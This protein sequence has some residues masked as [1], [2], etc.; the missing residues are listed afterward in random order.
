MYSLLEILLLV[1]LPNVLCIIDQEGPQQLC[2]G[3]V[4]LHT[5]TQFQLLCLR[6]WMLREDAKEI[7]M[8]DLMVEKLPVMANVP[9][10][11]KR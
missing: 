1:G 8:H 10:N 7:Q 11:I 4:S 6:S 5:H 9:E 2:S 3:W